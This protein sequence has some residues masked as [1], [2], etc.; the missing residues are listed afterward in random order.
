MLR[1]TAPRNDT[2]FPQVWQS[3]YVSHTLKRTKFYIYVNF[4]KNKNF[5]NFACFRFTFV[6][7]YDI[8]DNAIIVAC[9]IEEINRRFFMANELF[10]KYYAKLRNEGILKA[11]LCALI[12]GFAALFV[13]TIVF[14]VLEIKAFL[15]CI[16]IFGAATLV[17]TPIFYFV[18]FRPNTKSIAKRI[19]ELGLE[20]RLLTMTQLEG[21][22]SYIAMKQREDALKALNSVNAGL[23]KFAVSASLIIAVSVSAILGLIPSTIMA[24]VETMPPVEEQLPEYTLTYKS[25]DMKMGKVVSWDGELSTSDKDVNGKEVGFVKLT[26]VEGEDAPQGVTAV[27]YDGYMFVAWSDEYVGPHGEITPYRLDVSVEKSA[28][29]WAIFAEADVGK[30][31][32]AD[33]EDL[34]DDMPWNEDGEP[35]ENGPEIPGQDPSEGTGGRA[36]ANNQVINGET[37]YGGELDGAISDAMEGVSGNGSIGGEEIGIIGGYLGGIGTN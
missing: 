12:V 16:A 3:F 30:D 4:V 17:A 6:A 14:M 37:Y 24:V 20:E 29:I 9:E 35:G 33:D 11:F 19:D 15:V 22:T 8:I 21:D 25:Q 23:I 10:R 31:D 36:E 1:R 18:K 32:G 2:D 13:S 5:I 27:P 34:P 7:E 26:A 28:T